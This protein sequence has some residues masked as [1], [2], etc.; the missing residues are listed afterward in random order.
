MTDVPHLWL[1]RPGQETLQRGI[2][3]ELAE[4]SA[5][6][7]HDNVIAPPCPACSE[8]VADKDWE[9]HKYEKHGINEMVRPYGRADAR[10]AFFTGYNKA[11]LEQKL[12]IWRSK[13]PGIPLELAGEGHDTARKVVWQR[14]RLFHGDGRP[15]T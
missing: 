8:P 1:G 12:A 14:Y 10:E 13:H 3:R 7:S 6:T 2:A 15:A 11:S 4:Q 9:K 5:E